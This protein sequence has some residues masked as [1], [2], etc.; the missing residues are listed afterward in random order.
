[1]TIQTYKSR[2]RTALPLPINKDV[3]SSKEYV[4][5]KNKK[6]GALTL[7]SLQRYKKNHMHYKH[8]RLKTSVQFNL[9]NKPASRTAWMKYG[10][11]KYL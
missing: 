7:R 3:K 6:T 2:G 9:N 5:N 1:M 4:I 10:K 8:L 11:V